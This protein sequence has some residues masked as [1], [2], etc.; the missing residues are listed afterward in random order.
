MIQ[1]NNLVLSNAQAITASAASTNV[2]DFGPTGIPY[3][4]TNPVQRDYGRDDEHAEIA[5]TVAA[6]FNNLTSLTVTVQ[7]S[8]DNST[9]S[10]V[11]AETYTLASGKLAA[12]TMLPIPNRIPM[13]STGR[14]FRLYYT[15]TGTAPSTGA[16]T[17]GFVANRQNNNQFGGQS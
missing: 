15:V 12:G 5:V 16:I 17:A 6:T 3:G 4:H 13:G 1:S 9:W 8:P 10:D 2:I 7:T 14:Y 11:Q